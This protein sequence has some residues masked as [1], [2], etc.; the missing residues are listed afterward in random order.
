MRKDSQRV[1]LKV[2]CVVIA[3]LFVA[4]CALTPDLRAV[5]VAAPTKGQAASAATPSP[6][7]AA[8]S[9]AG[10]GARAVPAPAMRPV[11]FT[12]LPSGTYPVHLHL[13]C[14]GR[15][16]FHLAYLP[17][18]R[19]AGSTGTISVPAADFGHSWCVIVYANP[20]LSAVLTTRRI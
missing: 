4:G 19:V 7:T 2:L 15:Q 9:V 1:C 14:S 6:P 5:T 20:S 3:T 11:T 12:G 10:K 17:S 18:L 13:I 8:G 16:G